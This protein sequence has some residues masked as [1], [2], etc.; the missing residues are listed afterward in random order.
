M[1]TLVAVYG[2][3]PPVPPP[4]SSPLTRPDRPLPHTSC[5][6]GHSLRA[7]PNDRTAGDSPAKTHADAYAPPAARSW[8]CSHS[9]THTLASTSRIKS[10]S[11][12][13]V[14]VMVR[15]MLL[16]FF[17]VDLTPPSLPKP[18]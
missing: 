8:F 15:Q 2:D 17:S 9:L 3:H 10:N 14:M 7:A 11:C 18:H 6:P 4:P 12:S 16:L 1:C 5:F 13:F